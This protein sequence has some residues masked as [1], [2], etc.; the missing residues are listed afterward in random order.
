[1]SDSP[2][3]RASPTHATLRWDAEGLPLSDEFDDYYFSKLDGLTETRYLY[4]EHNA[5]ESRWKALTTGEHFVI[6]ETG[7]GT[8]LS[9]LTSWQLWQQSA[10]QDAHLHFVSVE[11]APLHPQDLARSLALWPELKTLAD[12]LVQQYPPILHPGF[13]HLIFAEGRVRLTLIIGEACEGLEQL[14]QS[15][16]PAHSR[17][18]RGIDAWFLDGFSP[19]KNPDMWRTELFALVQQLSAPEATVSTFAAATI[20][21]RGLTQH[22]FQ[23]KTGKGFG[24]KREMVYGQLIEAAATE[25]PDDLPCNGFNAPHPAPWQVPRTPIHRPAIQQAIIIGGGIAGCHTARALANRGWQVTLLEQHSALAQ[26][27][28]GNPQGVLYAKLSHRQET[29]SD[30][31]LQALLFAQRAYQDYWQNCRTESSGEDD[32]S[33]GVRCGVLQLACQEKTVQLHDQLSQRHGKQTL[34]S[35][36]NAQQASEIS[37]IDLPFGGLF[38]PQAGWINPAKLCQWLTEHPN[39]DVVLNSSANQLHYDEDTQVWQVHTTDDKPAVYEAPTLI[40]TTA[41]HIHKLGFHEGHPLQEGQSLQNDPSIEELPLKP[42]RGQVTYVEASPQSQSLKTVLCGDGYLPPAAGGRHCL[43]ATFNPHSFDLNTNDED[44]QRNLTTM[45]AQTPS[46]SETFRQERVTGGR[47]ALRCTT[48]DYLPMVGA[49]PKYRELL[50]D[51]ALL[52]KN[53]RANI[54]YGAHYWEGL[55]INVGHGSRGLAYTPIC[56]EILAA[57]IHGEPTPVGQSVQN[58]LHPG[59]FWIRDLMRKKR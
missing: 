53:A 48:P 6:G 19:A 4:L 12:E 14:L 25:N 23:I 28:S 20:V 9:F 17:P 3:H 39:I 7:F 22:G 52:R 45:A 42:I 49:L 34:F 43:G 11:K 35:P 46:L 5:L 16:H 55:F 15:T 32:Q 40:I 38:F 50:D 2:I 24:R 51:Y 36:L 56:A 33:A 8:G 30:F 54:P 26:E 1:M 57:Q 31:N 29:L 27:G 13:H 41:S 58:A 37:G 47:A 44:H 59:R 10:P 18:Q 21:K